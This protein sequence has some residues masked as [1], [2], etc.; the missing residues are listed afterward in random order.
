MPVNQPTPATGFL[1]RLRERLKLPTLFT[2]GRVDEVHLEE[3]ET[4]LISADVGVDA[5]ARI[6][7]DLR[8]EAPHIGDGAALRAALK[9]S[10]VAILRPVA[11]PR[12]SPPVTH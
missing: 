10:L 9:A 4:Q 12:Q 2:G 7:A 11:K 3:L 8:R 5:S 1:A 6:I